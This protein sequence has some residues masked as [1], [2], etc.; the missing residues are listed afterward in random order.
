MITFVIK[1]AKKRKLYIKF[2][3]SGGTASAVDLFFLF[4]LTHIFGIWYLLS[5]SLA[6]IIAFFV[7][8]YLQKFWTFRDN[9]R[10]KMIKQMA[11]YFTVGVINLAVNTVG[12]YVLVD[13]FKIMY[14][15]AQIIMMALVAISNFLIYR[16]V[17]F[18]KE[19]LSE[20]I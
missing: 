15:V 11:L 14:L 20:K 8:F 13:K 1:Q 9:N 2:I 12:M 10:E 5:A 3:I 17:I 4:L 19:K 18:R 6:F 7:S 16:F